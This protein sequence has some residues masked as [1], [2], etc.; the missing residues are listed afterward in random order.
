MRKWDIGEPMK[1]GTPFENEVSQAVENYHKGIPI[2][3]R[4]SVE[5]VVLL[6]SPEWKCVGKMFTD[7]GE[8]DIYVPTID[9]ENGE[10]DIFI[11][12]PTDIKGFLPVE[13]HGYKIKVRRFQVI[14]A[15]DHCRYELLEILN[16]TV[17]PAD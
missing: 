17:S 10:R 14:P 5:E 9:A 6:V 8:K 2:G 3:N 1:C 4:I 15:P 13:G 7:E 11:L 16:E 12:F